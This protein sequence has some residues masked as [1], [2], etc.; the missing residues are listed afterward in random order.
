MQTNQLD[1]AKVLRPV[2]QF[3][4]ITHDLLSHEL[5]DLFLERSVLVDELMNGSRQIGCI[6]KERLQPAQRILRYVIELIRLGCSNR[7]DTTN[8]GS[9]TGLHQNTYTSDFTGRRHM[10]STT[11]FDRRTIFDH[12]Y[13]VP[14]FLSE[15]RHGPQCFRLSNR[16]MTMLLQMNILTDDAVGQYLHLTQLFRR[17]FL[18]VREV[19]TQTVRCNERTLLLHVFTQHFAQRVVQDMGR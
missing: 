9:N 4:A 7:L 16:H 14:V 3:I 12:T 19:K 11:K 8:T 17:Y 1:I 5:L 18:E 15:E 13:I 6:V 2:N 10:A